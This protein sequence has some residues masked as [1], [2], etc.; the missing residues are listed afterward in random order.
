MISN[1]N[2]NQTARSSNILKLNELF[3]KLAVTVSIYF[4]I[5]QIVCSLR[6]ISQIT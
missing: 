3:L 2:D 4:I 1:T 5:E 6:N